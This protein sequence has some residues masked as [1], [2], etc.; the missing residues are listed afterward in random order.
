MVWLVPAALA[1]DLLLG[2]PRFLPHP[3]VWIGRLI[4][5]LE[6]LAALVTNQRLAGIALVVTTLGA[7][8]LA[9]WGLLALA[10]L[11]HPLL[12]GVL[13]LWLA[14]TTLALRSLHRE[15]REVVELVAEGSLEE[16]RR[17]LS[18]LVGRQTS[19]LD[20]EGVLRA[21]L[22]KVAANTSDAVIAPLFYLFIGGPV[23]ALLFRAASTLDSMIGYQTERY[24]PLGWTA[25]WLDD[26]LNWP[27]ARLTALLMVLAAPLVGLRPWG[28][29]RITLRDA[30]KIQSPNAGWPEAAAAGALGVQLG[31]E[32]IYFGQT[33][34][35]PTL[36][37]ASRPLTIDSYRRMVRLMYMTSLLALGLGVGIHL[38]LARAFGAP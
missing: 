14:Y 18:L 5:R 30:R 13:A 25:A 34:A 17:A 28:A 11:F 1:L 15:S 4:T 21:C 3:V 26:L 2:D 32:A 8:G 37:D 35:R 10:A 22:E 38:V 12:Q 20:R 29:L 27:P 16:A 24:S 36:G 33:V 6:L 31:G 7:T 9:T 19:H 23:A